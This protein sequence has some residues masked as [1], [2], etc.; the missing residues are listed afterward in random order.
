MGALER[1]AIEFDGLKNEFGNDRAPLGETDLVECNAGEGKGA[2]VRG[3][4]I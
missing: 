3:G 1:I 4:G 2:V